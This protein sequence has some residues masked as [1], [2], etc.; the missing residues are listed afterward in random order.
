MSK[1]QKK[2]VVVRVIAVGI[3]LIMVFPLFVLLLG[4]IL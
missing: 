4:L 1:E 3:A 2:R